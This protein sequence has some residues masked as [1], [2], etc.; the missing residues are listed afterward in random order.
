M[1]SAYRLPAP[2]R[3]R[4]L[5]SMAL[6]GFVWTAGWVCSL[7]WQYPSSTLFYKFGVDR[8]MLL[9]GKSAGMAAGCLLLFQLITVARMPGL[10]RVVSQDRLVTLHR[11]TGWL[12]VSLAMLHP[13]LV[14]AMEDLTAIPVSFDYWPEIVGA[15]LL[16]LLSATALLTRGRDFSGIPHGYW[17]V[18]HRFTALAV[19]V[20]LVVHLLFVNDGYGAGP[21]RQVVMAGAVIVGLLWAW[22]AVRPFRR[23]HPHRVDKVLVAGKDGVTLVLRPVNGRPLAHLPGQFVY[24]R[25]RSEA[26]SAEEHPFTIASQPGRPEGLWLTIRC[27]GDWTRRIGHVRSGDLV[28]VQGPHG[29]FSP[30]A[31]DPAERL[32]FIAGGVGIT[33]MLSI[34][35]ALAERGDTHR[36]RL[37][38]SNR[39]RADRVH[40]DVIKNLE[41]SLPGLQ[42]T[43][44]FTRE[45]E[46]GCRP[47]GITP[48]RLEELL[49][50]YQ[51]GTL[52]FLCG[53]SEFMRRIKDHLLRLGYPRRTLKTETFRM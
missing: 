8:V 3:R 32:V 10:T 22:I 43:H 19:A 45:A 46:A 11:W 20:L 33:P 21:P 42:T 37:I 36:I 6:M 15:G 48:E 16:V 26:L 13:L 50:P 44:I 38:W 18:G 23:P 40:P 49:G 1:S 5:A 34:L 25:I 17:K 39:T 2:R 9:A 14:F 27:S 41:R 35:R 28:F 4:L 24:I 29:C 53:P 7:P 52:V 12:L 47:E 30:D 51:V 31:C